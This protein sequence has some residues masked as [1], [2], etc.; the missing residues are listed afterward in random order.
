MPNYLQNCQ[1]N[2]YTFQACMYIYFQFSPLSKFSHDSN[3]IYIRFL[4]LSRSKTH[5]PFYKVKR[6]SDGNTYEEM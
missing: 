5:V 4:Q 2:M 1:T 6:K 3:P